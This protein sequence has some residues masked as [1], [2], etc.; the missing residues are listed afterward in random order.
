MI[1]IV[2]SPCWSK[3][4]RG[5]AGIDLAESLVSDAASIAGATGMPISRARQARCGY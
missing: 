3:V 1:V 4:D 5:G 2:Y